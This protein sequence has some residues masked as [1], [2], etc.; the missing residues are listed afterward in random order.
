MAAPDPLH[1]P[2]DLATL[3]SAP[4][5][6]VKKKGWRRLM[7]TLQAEGDGRLLVTNHDEPQAVILSAEAYL[8]MMR[9]VRQG[10]APVQGA[11]EELRARFDERLVAL[12][13]DDA[14]ERLRAVMRAPAAL[15]GEVKAGKTC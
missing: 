7:K 13:A 15:A 12:A 14:G 9:L 3:A 2:D 5:S 8:D 11:L 4:A 1:E 6:D 10:Q